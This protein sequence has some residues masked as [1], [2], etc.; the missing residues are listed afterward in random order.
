MKSSIAAHE[1]L[2]AVHQ[3]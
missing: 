1:V 2:S 3:C